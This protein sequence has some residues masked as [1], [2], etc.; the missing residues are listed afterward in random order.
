MVKKDSECKSSVK[1]L[2]DGKVLTCWKDDEY[3]YVSFPWC[4]VNFPLESWKEVQ[5]DLLKL[6]KVR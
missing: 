6:S 5:E 2:Y 1:D 3:V 4:C